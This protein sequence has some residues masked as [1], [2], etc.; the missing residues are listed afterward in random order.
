[1]L[2]VDIGIWTYAV[3]ALRLRQSCAWRPAMPVDISDFP[4]D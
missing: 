3:G 1:M 2:F 4:T